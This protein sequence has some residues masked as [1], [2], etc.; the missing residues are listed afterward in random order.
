M[1]SQGHDER[2][3]EFLDAVREM[4]ILG[5]IVL[6]AG[7]LAVTYLSTGV[8]YLACNDDDDGCTAS[9]WPI[10]GAV[11]AWIGLICVIAWLI[12]ALARFRRPTSVLIVLTV[13]AYVAWIFT[14][15]AP[16]ASS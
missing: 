16:A 10:P 3:R 12:S 6:L 2:Q 13:G 1:L 7:A 14:F 4:R 8:A 15:L 9:S 11:F 5:A